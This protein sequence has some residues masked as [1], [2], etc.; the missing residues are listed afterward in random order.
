[1]QDYSD[2]MAPIVS[3]TCY[4]HAFLCAV[5]PKKLWVQLLCITLFEFMIDK[6]LK[7]HDLTTSELKSVKKNF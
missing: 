4:M 7:K 2:T 6:F 5:C 1:M 3:V